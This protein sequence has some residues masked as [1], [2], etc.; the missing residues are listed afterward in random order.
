M[1]KNFLRKRNATV[2]HKAAYKLSKASE[3]GAD[4][5]VYGAFFGQSSM[6]RMSLV[7]ESSVSRNEHRNLP[8]LTLRILVRQGVE[9]P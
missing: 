4:T 6:A 9:R 7:S 5:E 1:N 8:L 2:E 3:D